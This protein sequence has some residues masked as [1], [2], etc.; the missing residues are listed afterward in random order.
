MQAINKRTVVTVRDTF[1]MG[2][3]VGKNGVVLLWASSLNY[4]SIKELAGESGTPNRS[5]LLMLIYTLVYPPPHVIFSLAQMGNAGS[6]LRGG[7]YLA[8][9]MLSRSV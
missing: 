7:T 4:H 6:R 9:G 5:W 2:W 1:R 8:R 3:V